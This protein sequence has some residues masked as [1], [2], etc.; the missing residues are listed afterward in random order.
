MGNTDQYYPATI[1]HPGLILDE[2]LQEIGMGP[3]EFAVRTGKPE[4]TI[5]ALLKAKSSIT[6]DMAVLF[7]HVTRIP[8]H[9]WMN[10]QRGFD[11]YIARE[12]HKK[13]VEE[14][15]GWAK[16]F[17]LNEMMTMDW[18]PKL[19]SKEKKT[20]SLLSFFGFANH[21]AWEGYYFNQLLKVTFRISLSHFH[22]PYALSAWLRKGELQAAEIHAKTYSARVFKEKLSEIE[23][24]ESWETMAVLNQIREYCLDAG[25]KFVLTP[26][27]KKVHVSGSV[28]WINDTPLIQIAGNNLNEKTLVFTFFH[29]AG[30]ILLHGKKEVFIENIEYGDKDIEKEKEA[31]EFASTWVK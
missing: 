10:H 23:K 26:V 25:V 1:H 9:Y 8:A 14:A 29:E 12:K 7:E 31:D 13:V 22:E 16:H 24:F 18:L 4:K 17:P 28:R 30:H 3:K 19:S 27:L 5:I 20:A 21:K 6:P 2:K 15:L 11:E